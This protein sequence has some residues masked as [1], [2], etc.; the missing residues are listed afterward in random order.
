M[1]YILSSG[2]IGLA[3]DKNIGDRQVWAGGGLDNIK[4][5]GGSPPLSGINIAW[6]HDQIELNKAIIA[7]RVDNFKLNFS[8]HETV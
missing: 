2:Q 5:T 7:G 3:V 6:I 8:I 1:C 4:I